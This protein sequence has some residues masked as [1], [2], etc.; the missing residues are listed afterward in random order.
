MAEYTGSCLSI[1]MNDVISIWS[2]IKSDK[3]HLLF[4]IAATTRAIFHYLIKS[5]L[6]EARELANII[7]LTC[8]FGIAISVCETYPPKWMTQ[9][10][11]A[12]VKTDYQAG[13]VK[14]AAA[15]RKA[16]VPVVR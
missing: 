3:G 9:L 2:F 16:A 14:R 13:P 8:I 1:L 12:C 4:L 15:L 11:N 5:P 6:R 10:A 7:T